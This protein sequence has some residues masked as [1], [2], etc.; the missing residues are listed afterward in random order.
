MIESISI[1]KVAS[2]NETGIQINNIKKINFIYGTNAGGKTT[3]SNLATNPTD[4][5]FQYCSISWE[6]R[7]Q[8]KTLVYNKNFRDHNFS[9]SSK[10]QGVFALGE[11]TQKE[12]DIIEEIKEKSKTIFGDVP[13]SIPPTSTIAFDRIDEIEK[14]NDIVN[15]NMMMGI[16]NE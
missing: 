11:A 13:V 6:H 9:G 12:I 1:K 8:L 14:H 5:I 10:L 4:S 3:I 2:F 7:Q 15:N 16:S